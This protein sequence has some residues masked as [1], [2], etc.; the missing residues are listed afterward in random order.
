MPGSRSRLSD[1]DFDLIAD[2]REEGRTYD[3]IGSRVGCSGKLV[4]W[5]CLRLGI[6]APN[7]PVLPE[8]PAV[9]ITIKR[10]NHEVRRFTRDEDA[11]LKAMALAGQGDAIIARALSRRPNSVRGRLMTLARRDERMGVA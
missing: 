2:M 5:H 1:A 4:S 9:P 11:R 10:G 8:I 7:G 3:E 6:D